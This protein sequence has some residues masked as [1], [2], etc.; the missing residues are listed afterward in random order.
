M[1][2]YFPK[3]KEI[4]CQWHLIDA[5]GKVLARLTTEI[6]RLLTGKHKPTYTPHLDCGDCVVVI[7]AAK[8]I[9]SGRK[10]EDKI[11]RHHTGYLGGLKEETFKQLTNK[12]PTRP[13]M[14]AV[15]GMLPKNKLRK[16]R[17]ARLKIFSGSTHPYQDR[18]KKEIE[19]GKKTK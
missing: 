12:D 3:A 19:N 17:L 14:L 16:Q 6:V 9:I 2:T 4:T 10:K 8:I 13:L 5:E 15:K 18:F 11:Y 1:R 7:N